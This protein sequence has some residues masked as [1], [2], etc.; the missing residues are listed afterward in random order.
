MLSNRVMMSHISSEEYDD[1]SGSPGNNMLVAGNMTA[2]YFGEVAASLLWTGADLATACGIT[3]GRT[4]SSF[5]TEPWLKFA[6]KGKIIFKAKKIFRD[7]L[8]W[9]YLEGL[10]CIDGT[11]E[12]TKEGLTYK[13]RLMTGLKE[14]LKNSF[15]GDALFG[16]EW[17]S[18]LLPIHILAATQGWTEPDNVNIPTEN[19]DI[20]FTNED[21]YMEDGWGKGGRILT[22]YRTYDPYGEGSYRAIL[23][24]GSNIER[25]ERTLTQSSNNTTGWSPV[26]EVDY[27][28]QGL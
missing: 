16:S 20:N 18:L 8:S 7:S 25:A 12:L 14:D 21:L 5:D 22:Q 10:G 4:K 27:P 17:N 2:G 11:T 1:N 24:S 9:D 6:S 13:V 26:L 3:G 28:V 19:W 23:R 15:T